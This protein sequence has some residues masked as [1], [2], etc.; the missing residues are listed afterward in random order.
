VLTGRPS[1]VSA[2][3]RRPQRLTIGLVAQTVASLCWIGSVFAYGIEST[4]D[5]LQLAAASSWL[6]A[7]IASFGGSAD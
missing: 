3:S 5:W 7:N 6:T 4:G 1:D 2:P